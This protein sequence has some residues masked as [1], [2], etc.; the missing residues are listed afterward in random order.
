MRRGRRQRFQSDF[1]RSM[2]AFKLEIF[3]RKPQKTSYELIAAVVTRKDVYGGSA[4]LPTSHDIYFRSRSQSAA[5]AT[6]RRGNEWEKLENNVVQLI[7]TAYVNIIV[8][9]LCANNFCYLVF[10]LVSKTYYC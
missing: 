10:V 3:T 8:C 5:R 1:N 7:F 6:P 2:C 4:D 9:Y